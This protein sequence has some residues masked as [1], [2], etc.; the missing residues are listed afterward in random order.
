VGVVFPRKPHANH[1]SGRFPKRALCVDFTQND[2]AATNHL[3]VT[4]RVPHPWF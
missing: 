2:I 3:A 1:C 4:G